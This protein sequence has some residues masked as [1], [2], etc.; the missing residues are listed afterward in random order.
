VTPAQHAQAKRIF[1]AACE[2][3]SAEQLAYLEAACAEDTELH[4]HLRAL[5]A[6]HSGPLGDAV[7]PNDDPEATIPATGGSGGP[8]AGP[9]A[10]AESLSAGTTIA[11]RYRIVS[12][13]GRGGMGDVYRAEDLVLDETVALKFLRRSRLSD[14]AWRERF[15]REVQSARRITHPNI[16]RVHDIHLDREHNDAFIS[17]AFI[18]GED[19]GTLIRRIGRLPLET[20][21]RIA[22]QICVGLAAAHAHG[23]LHR[24]L[25]PANI[26]IDGRGEVRITDFGL[27]A[28]REQIGA[29]EIAAGTPAYM[30]PELFA[31]TDV[32][33]RSDIYALGLVLYELLSGRRAFSGESLT[34]LARAHQRSAA[35]PLDTI[36]SN[37]PAA[38]ADIVTRCLAKAPQQRPASAIEVA[39]ALPGS[40]PLSLA[41]AAGVTLAPEHVAGATSERGLRRFP[42]L[43]LAAGVPLGLVAAAL[44]AVP[45]GMQVLEASARP[46]PV[47][48]D[49]ARRIA[50]QTVRTTE[51]LDEAAGWSFSAADVLAGN[52]DA[53]PVPGDVAARPYFWYR[54]SAEQLDPTAALNLTFGRSRV[55]LDDPPR[56]RPG[57]LTVVLDS[58]GALRALEHTP[59]LTPAP[60]GAAADWSEILAAT[61]LNELRPIPPPDGLRPPVRH[62][63]V[64]AWQGRDAAQAWMITTASTAAQP[65]WLSAWP[66]GAGQSAVPVASVNDRR[67]NAAIA[68]ITLMILVAIVATPLA[69]INLAR[70]RSDVN[71]ALRIAILVVVV[72]LLSWLLTSSHAAELTTEFRLVLFAV[73]GAQFE[74]L[75]VWTFYVALEPYVRRF[76]PQALISWT[77]LLGGDSGDHLVGRDL[78]VGAAVGVVTILVSFADRLLPELFGLQPRPPVHLH[79]ALEPLLGARFALAAM[80]SSALAAVFLGLL[81]VVFLLSLRLCLR[82]NALAIVVTAVLLVPLYLPRM[83]HPATSWLP[84]L[85]LLVLVGWVATRFGLLAIV[86]TTLTVRWF[87]TLPVSFVP[88]A[89]GWDLA[90]L[91]TAGIVAIAV[92]GLACSWQQPAH[93]GHASA[94]LAAS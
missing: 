78:L 94:R 6:Q 55:T 46:T 79:Y 23:I 7:G 12:Q 21:I 75:L 4:A 8:V 9:R 41:Q 22:R 1:L 26:M 70:R 59:S 73:L 16:C 31:G 87:T 68:L 33:V 54:R 43:L 88:G 28:T 3:P 84:L 10:H 36:A 69:I 52:P 48:L 49:T 38:V 34:E 39:A 40:D 90:L 53:R 13:L 92:F 17:M 37:V 30:A 60:A 58:R 89:V 25:K 74:G 65:V 56:G 29:T 81:F 66:T 86:I 63:T 80:L 35:T 44:L 24:D 57:M 85:V 76:W 14:P 42:S 71:G 82:H 45:T 27:A 5:L 72:R 83:A 62:D 11:G 61:G 19:L 32:S 91:V 64:A 93:P 2:L 50:D 20:A 67:Q 18:D 15:V 51:P 77:R 47:L